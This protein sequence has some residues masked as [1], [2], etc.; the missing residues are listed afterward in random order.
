VN[1]EGLSNPQNHQRERGRER[2]REIK[3][4]KKGGKED[5][6]LKLGALLPDFGNKC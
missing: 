2:E 6:D 1:L 3:S 5:L 4:E